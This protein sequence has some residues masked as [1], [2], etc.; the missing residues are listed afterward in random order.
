MSAQINR[1]WASQSGATAIEYSLIAAFI[2]IAI[3]SVLQT[4]GIEVRG[5][6]EDVDKG[7][8]KRTL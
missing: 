6:F 2:G 7:L 3:V 4:V 5:P 1:F 8:K